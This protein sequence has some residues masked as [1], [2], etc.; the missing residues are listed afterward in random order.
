[1]ADR[2]DSLNGWVWANGAVDPPAVPVTGVT[3][4]TSDLTQTVVEAGWPYNQ[5]ANGA[6]FNEMMGRITS[7]I[8]NIE[9]YGVLTWCPT[10]TYQTGAMVIASNDIAYRAVQS[11]LNQDPIS[12]TTGAYWERLYGDIGRI[13]IF[14]LETAP[15]GW[16]ECNG[17]AI[18]RTTY[19]ALFSIIGTT[20]G[21]GNGSTTFNIPDYRGRF[22]R[23]WDHSLGLDPD[24]ASRTNRGD[25]VSGDH[26]GTKQADQYES[27]A[28]QNQSLGSANNVTTSAGID[29][30]AYIDDAA[31]TNA[32]NTNVSGGN[33]TRPVNIN[34]MFCIK[35]R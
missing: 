33:E 32:L 35:Y 12:D 23:G 24:A 25:G 19:S 30:A 6:D 4:A 16:L 31:F 9:K 2:T 14:P 15:V 29:D 26:V 28:H 11:N 17:A 3:Y 7:L 1:M 5:I 8:E 10:I 27:H 21:A 34:V 13:G 18:S 22:L 20:H